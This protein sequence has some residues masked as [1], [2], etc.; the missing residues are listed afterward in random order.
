M[1]QIPPLSERPEDIPMLATHFLSRISPEMRIT[2][3]PDALFAL[4]KARWPGNVRQLKNVLEQAASLTLNSSIPAILIRR[5]IR[6]CDEGTLP[7]FDDA[8]KEFERDYLVRLLETT[9]GNVA[10][11]ARVAHR[12][13]TEFYK[14]LAKHGLDPVSFK[15]KFL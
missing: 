11:A 12:N 14:L 7:A 2:L 1:V 9:A 10:R 4:Q 6:E 15:Q 13:R 5:V 8:R 3:T